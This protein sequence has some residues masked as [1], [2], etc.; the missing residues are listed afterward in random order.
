MTAKK[1]KK[2]RGE[3]LTTAL[4]EMLSAPEKWPV[5]VPLIAEN[6]AA[7]FGIS[8]QAIYDRDV[9][10]VAL[11]VAQE[12]MEKMSASP[13]RKEGRRD[14]EERLQD[15]LAKISELERQLDKWREKW[16]EMENRCHARNLNPNE[17]LGS[18]WKAPS[19]V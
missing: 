12:R 10:V 11:R 16:L 13:M 3:A 4:L 9:V 19:Q 18:V 15:A 6:L 1:S 14:V 2:L 7:A 5:G 8:R 17:I